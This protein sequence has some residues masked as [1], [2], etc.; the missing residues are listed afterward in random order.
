MI[1]DILLQ[2]IRDMLDNVSNSTYDLFSPLPIYLPQEDG[3]KSESFIALRSD[4][5]EEH[6]TLEKY[7]T[8]S[9]SVILRTIPNESGNDGTTE[10]EHRAIAKQLY[11]FLDCRNERVNDLNNDN[12][13]NVFD[14]RTSEPRNDVDEGNLSVI[15]Q[16]V[17]LTLS[18]SDITDLPTDDDS[19]IVLRNGF[20]DY[21]N[22]LN[23]TTLFA[24]QWTTLPNNG[25]GGFTNK[26]FPPSNV[27][28]LMDTGNGSIDTTQLNL[29][30]TILIR[31]D[32]S[33]TPS[34]N[35]ALLEMRYQ[36]GSGSNSYTL[37]T[38]TSRLDDGSGKAYRFSLKPDLIYMGDENT[39]ANPIVIQI[40][41]STDGTV[42]NAG[43]VIQVIR[44]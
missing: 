21:N 3:N 23:P 24:D 19:K 13:I 15:G 26:N 5:I 37:E 44:R 35:N 18:D 38:V 31:N 29:G 36:L 40:K 25:Q 16:T 34:T 11:D 32:F 2:S 7:F 22:T 30:D 1:E 41:L 43:S 4:G 10:E 17:V 33:V 14:F 9:V 39:R 12:G 8:M 42:S 20:I 6:E 27:T 28:E